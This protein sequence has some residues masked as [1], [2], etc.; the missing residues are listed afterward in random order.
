VIDK[1]LRQLLD[2]QEIYEVLLRYTRGLDRLDSALLASCYH[3]DA[4]HDHG[5]WKG[6]AVEFVEYCATTLATMDRT[7]HVV[8]NALITL[9]GEA[10]AAAETY[11]AALH[12]VASTK[13]PSGF[14]NH[15]VHLRYVDRF[16]RRD[17]GPWRIARRTVVFEWSVIEPITREWRLTAEYERGSRTRADPAYALGVLPLL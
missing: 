9:D 14:A 3:A 4:W 8:E 15:T 5:M 16:E 7:L 2:K 11:C 13:S 10:S 1:D 12:R 6:P 17:G